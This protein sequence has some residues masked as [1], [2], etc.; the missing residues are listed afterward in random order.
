[1]STN[2]HYATPQSNRPPLTHEANIIIS[3]N[4]QNIIRIRITDIYH[5]ILQ[6]TSHKNCTIKR[7]LE[8]RRAEKE[9]LRGVHCMERGNFILDFRK[10]KNDKL[11]SYFEENCMGMETFTLVGND[12]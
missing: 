3:Y 9:G 8:Q 1:M 12:V 2:K 7:E 10:I 4:L 5:K 11:E 6:N